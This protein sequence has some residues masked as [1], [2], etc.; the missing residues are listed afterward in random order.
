MLLAQ[1]W[2]QRGNDMASGQAEDQWGVRI[3][4]PDTNTIAIGAPFYDAN[5]ISNRGLVRV[6]RWNGSSW[7]QH[8]ND[9]LGSATSHN[10]GDCVVMSSAS[11]LTLSTQGNTA[12]LTYRL[13]GS[14]WIRRG[15]TLWAETVSDNFGYALAMPDSNTLAIGTPNRIS[16]GGF[17]AGRV[18]VYRYNG[19]TWVPK[20]DTID[21]PSQY[22]YAG[23]ALSMPDPNT[24]AVSMSGAR[25]V[26]VYTL[27]PNNRWIQKG[28]PLS[29]PNGGAY[30]IDIGK[31]I[32]MP[33]PNTIA[34]GAPEDG[35]T[36]G[37]AGQPA[38]V[39]RVYAW[40]GRNWVQKGSALTG[41]DFGGQFGYAVAMPRPDIVVV[42]APS[43][44]VNNINTGYVRVYRYNGSDWVL[45]GQTI[46]GSAEYNYFG[47]DVQAPDTHIWGP[48]PRPMRA[49]SS[50]LC[51]CMRG[52]SL[53][54]S[55]APPTTL[56]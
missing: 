21:G 54:L 49:V 38:G 46:P 52:S 31:P 12:V 1:N 42:G 11:T 32:S 48:V 18:Y 4:M 25:I 28:P 5:S 7:M 2:S 17:E 53:P 44:D 29:I 55:W 3:S 45:W 41:I 27:N 10:L 51:A 22:A 16:S 23:S 8:G 33:D 35:P 13:V 37:P 34:I 24:M 9:I 36:G 26:Q 6:Y 39:V 20:G 14:N 50:V 43:G 40:S 30:G 47:R 19:T 15:D 56:V